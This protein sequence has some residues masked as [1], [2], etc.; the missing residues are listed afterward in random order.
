MPASSPYFSRSLY[1]FMRD[2]KKNNNR[3]WFAKNKKRYE[4]VMLKPSLRF[5][6]DV[7]VQLKKVSPQLVA[8]PKPFGGSLFRIYRDIRF[9]KDKSPYKTNLAMEFWHKKA[10]G[11]SSPGLYLHIQPGENF[12]GAGVWHPETSELTKIRKAITNDPNSWKTVLDSKLKLEG[13]T[14]KRPPAGFGAD[15]QFIQDIKRKDFISSVPFTD[16][17]I[18][19]PGFLT[20]FIEAGKK[21]NPLNKF[22]A[23]A[24][25]LP[26]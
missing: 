23:Q 18:T 24:I 3:E 21:T 7:G 9:S 2:L 25:G 15:H 14:L 1:T 11:H 19:S 5:I 16:R 13:D 26:W 17:Q 22:L 10:T 20:E 4:T 8:D 6:K 12:L